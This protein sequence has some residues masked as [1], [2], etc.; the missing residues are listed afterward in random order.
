[1]EM[2]PLVIQANVR[3]PWEQKKGLLFVKAGLGGYCPA[4]AVSTHIPFPVQGWMTAARR[5]DF[6]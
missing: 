5:A 2:A 1:M 4:R 6:Q 3:P